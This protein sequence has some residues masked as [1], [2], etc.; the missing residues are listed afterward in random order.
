MATYYFNAKVGKQNMGLPH[1]NY[2]FREQKYST[3]ED[4]LW[5]DWG[6]LPEWAQDDPA[7]F[8]QAVQKYEKRTPYREYVI[9]LPEELSLRENVDLVKE[10]IDHDLGAVQPYSFSIHSVPSSVEKGHTNIHA[11]IMFSERML[12]PDREMSEEQFFKRYSQKKDGTICGGA[13]K[14]RKYS[15]DNRRANLVELRKF[16]ADLQNK[17]Y[18]K[19]K[20]DERV[21]HRSLKQM[22]KDLRLKGEL[23]DAGEKNRPA[24]TRLPIG[25]VKSPKF[26]EQ[27]KTGSMDDWNDEIAYN[28][29]ALLTKRQQQNLRREYKNTPDIL[30]IHAKEFLV[31]QNLKIQKNY[32]RNEKRINELKK[33]VVYEN[34]IDTV[35]RNK[36]TNG[37]Y[38][39]LKKEHRSLSEKINWIK[40]KEKD[41]KYYPSYDDVQDKRKFNELHNELMRLENKYKNGLSDF[42]VLR[43]KIV[44]QN[45]KYFPQFD[46]LKKA[47]YRLG[48]QI[49]ENKAT[50]DDLITR[51]DN[52]ILLSKG[53]ISAGRGNISISQKLNWQKKSQFLPKVMES[54]VASPTIQLEARKEMDQE[55]W[56]QLQREGKDTGMGI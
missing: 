7:K 2:I 36:L 47:N 43:E 26:D 35:V 34:A 16:Y 44:E 50:L 51:P 3:R 24:R 40:E 52:E 18:E 22:A 21:D 29:H 14:N 39:K 17:Y 48:K 4:N 27:I 46:R 6:N 54:L 49:E 41:S 38:G 19:N 5:N 1:F 32:D 12:E 55:D 31:K 13:K 45:K 23:I 10:L 25:I 53:R 15:F 11:H 30:V 9:A 20:R 37:K 56:R 28:R 8:W 42:D 33:F